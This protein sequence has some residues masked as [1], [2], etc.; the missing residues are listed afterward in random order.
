MELGALQKP[1]LRRARGRLRVGRRPPVTK[2]HGRADRATPSR[3]DAYHLLLLLLLP[4]G[5]EE[6]RRGRRAKRHG[7]PEPERDG[8]RQLATAPATSGR[9]R[10]KRSPDRTVS[11]QAF[12]SRPRDALAA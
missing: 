11:A 7:T 9:R 3:R 4:D 1:H 2:E 5:H 10:T 8:V 12:R 6:Q